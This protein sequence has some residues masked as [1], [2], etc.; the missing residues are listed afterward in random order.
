MLLSGRA[1]LP[2]SLDQPCHFV[3]RGHIN[4]PSRKLQEWGDMTALFG[5]LIDY[6]KSERDDASVTTSGVQGK[7]G[8]QGPTDKQSH[9]ACLMKLACRQKS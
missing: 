5:F 1:S 6:L 2:G 8:K 9:H 7:C 3:P 4:E